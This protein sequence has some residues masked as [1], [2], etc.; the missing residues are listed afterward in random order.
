MAS[1]LRR[2]FVVHFVVDMLFGLPL[3]LFPDGVMGLFG[4]EVGEQV[5]VRLVG[6]ALI[7]IGGVSLW[8]NKEGREV[9]AALLR[10][11]LL[12]SGSAIVGAGLSL[13]YGAPM[14]ILVVLVVFMA[15]FLVW[16]YYYR[17]LRCKIF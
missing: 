3:L 16:L 6:A 2:W 13:W 11:K 4:L 17:R 10:L 8:V 5:T 1:S 7:G 12:W 14:M 9:Y 15:F